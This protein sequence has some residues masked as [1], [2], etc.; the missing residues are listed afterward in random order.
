MATWVFC[1]GCSSNVTTGDFNTGAYWW[2]ASTA[3]SNPLDPGNGPR[4]VPS[5]TPG[6]QVYW[7]TQ[8]DANGQNN[9]LVSDLRAA[10]G[11]KQGGATISSPFQQSGYSLQNAAGP[12]SPLSVGSGTNPPDG[13]W[14]S[15]GPFTVVTDSGNAGKK[16]RY[17]FVLTAALA[18]QA[19]YGEDPQM[20]VDNNN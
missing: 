4:F 5:F 9:S 14:M 3:T 12:I 20:D 10:I 18:N 2:N 16:S 1:I 15:I 11:R 13:P 19:Q 6:D 7:A 17:A 8:V